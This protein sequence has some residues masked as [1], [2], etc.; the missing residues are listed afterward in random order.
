MAHVI[1]H[2]LARIAETFVEAEIKVLKGEPEEVILDLAS[3]GAVDCIVLAPHRTDTGEYGSVASQV[4]RR[5]PCTVHLV[6]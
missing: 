1:E 3:S 5:A 6:R 4:V 2:N